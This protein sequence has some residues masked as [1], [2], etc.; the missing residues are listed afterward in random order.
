M[1]NRAHTQTHNKTCVCVYC[2]GR[3]AAQE[4]LAATLWGTYCFYYIYLSLSIYLYLS[5]YLSVCPSVCL[6]VCIDTGATLLKR[7]QLRHFGVRNMCA[8]SIYLYC[9]SIYL[10]I[11]MY[12][13]LSICVSIYLSMCVYVCPRAPRC[14][15]GAS[16]NTLGYVLLALYL[17]IDTVYPSIHLYVYI[18]LS[19]YVS[20]C[21]STGATLLKRR[22]LRH[23]GVRVPDRIIIIIILL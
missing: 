3:H 17:S 4:A 14:S 2:H 1:R 7:R 16:C 10:S 13:Y 5:I 21:V 20:V 6:C 8:I 12:I 19:V 22:Q 9:I 11:Y 18:Y 15:R 23:C